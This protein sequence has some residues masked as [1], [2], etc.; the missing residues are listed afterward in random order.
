[1]PQAFN[2]KGMPLAFN[3]KG[4]P[5][6][7]NRKGTPLAFNRK[8][9]PLAF[10]RKGTPL[11]LKVPKRTQRQNLLNRGDSIVYQ[12]EGVK[13]T[14]LNDNNVIVIAHT[15]LPSPGDLVTCEHQIGREKHTIPQPKGEDVALYQVNWRLP[16]SQGRRS[17]YTH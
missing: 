14:A 13:V 11:A 2:S 15:H 12:K 7:F 17:S 16:I 1:M 6:A 5:L 3:R 10:N 8:G 4:I 9:T